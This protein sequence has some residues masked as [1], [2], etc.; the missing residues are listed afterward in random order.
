MAL[1]T[2]AHNGSMTTKPNTATQPPE[3]LF[4][5]MRGSVIIAS[6]FDLTQPALLALDP[7]SAEFTTE[8]RRQAEALREGPEELEGLD[9]IETEAA[10]PEADE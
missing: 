5:S 3:D 9:Y 8:A 10:W 2:G 4:G 6:G 1:L 7:R